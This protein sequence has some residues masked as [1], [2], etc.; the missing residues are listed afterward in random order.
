MAHAELCRSQWAAVGSACREVSIGLGVWE[1]CL[2]CWRWFGSLTLL[3]CLCYY[4][5]SIILLASEEA[6]THA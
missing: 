2:C 6:L 3:Q 1:L 5:I 4:L